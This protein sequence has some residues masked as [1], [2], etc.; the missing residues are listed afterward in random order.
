M[1]GV[2]FDVD[3][4]RTKYAFERDRRIRDDGIAQYVEIAGPF[5]GFA[6]D[7][8]SDP[9]FTRSPLSDE[10]DV[11]IIGA[12]FGGLLTG[13]RLR[14]LGVATSGLSTR[15]PTWAAPGT[16]TGIQGSPVTSSRTCTCR[17]SRSW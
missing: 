6:K 5:A 10:V 3:A 1:P 12:G 14:E 2:S 7:P 11:A 15:P 16:G 8:W 9:G 17:C 4:L 13:A